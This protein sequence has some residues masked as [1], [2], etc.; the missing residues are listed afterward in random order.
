MIVVEVVTGSIVLMGMACRYAKH[1]YDKYILKKQYPKTFSKTVDKWDSMTLS[2]EPHESI[3]IHHA[4]YGSYDI[5]DWIQQ[6]MDTNF[7]CFSVDDLTLQSAIQKYHQDTQTETET[8]K[9][10]SDPIVIRGH[11]ILTPDDT[12]L[13]ISWSV[14]YI[15]N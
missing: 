7:L 13:E 6:N 2:T 9:P 8:N 10:P 12:R 14:Q 5:R 15:D 3:I 4:K 1:K 11:D